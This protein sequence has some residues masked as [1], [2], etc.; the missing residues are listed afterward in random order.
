[1][2]WLVILFI[3]QIFIESL[4]YA[5]QVKRFLDPLKGSVN[6]YFLTVLQNNNQLCHFWIF[7]YDMI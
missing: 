4:K 2:Y 6:S 7:R 5:G 1:M 3:Q